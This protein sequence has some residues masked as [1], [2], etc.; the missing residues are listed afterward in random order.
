MCVY[1]H[2]CESRR[3]RRRRRGGCLCAWQFVYNGIN[4]FPQEMI[5]RCKF[6]TRAAIAPDPAQKI[7]FM[8]HTICMRINIPNV[9][10]P[11]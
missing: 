5:V 2:E 6:R 8:G 3:R 1:L 10:Q 7:E 9:L 11:I 4:N